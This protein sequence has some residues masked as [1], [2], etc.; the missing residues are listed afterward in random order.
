MVRPPGKSFSELKPV[1]WKT[2][3]PRE[4]SIPIGGAGQTGW[5]KSA[6]PV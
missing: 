6:P 4:L 1:N 2:G 5:W 3:N